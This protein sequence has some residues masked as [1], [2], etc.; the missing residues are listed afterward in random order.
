M[1]NYAALK[2]ER[3]KLDSFTDSFSHLKKENYEKWPIKEQIA[4]W[5]NAYNSLTLKAIIDHYPVKA[6]FIGSIRFPKNSIRQ[7]SG[8]WSDLKFKVMR[9]QLTLNDIEHTILRKKYNEPGIHMALVCAAMG[10]PLLR[11]EPYTGKKLDGQLD[12]QAGRFLS[13]EKK[14]RIDHKKEKIYLSPIFKWFGKDFIKKYYSKKR[15][16]EYNKTDNSLLN[17]ISPH[18]SKEDINKISKKE[19]DIKFLNYDW[20]LNEQ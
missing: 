7:I 4:F 3:R 20:S 14:I 5:I 19:Y 13:S 10:C 9:K 17:F 18:I 11:R 8:V 2:K 1:V 15:F 6:S 12:D 16:T